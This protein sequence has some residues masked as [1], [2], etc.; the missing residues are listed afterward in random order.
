MHVASQ[1]WFFCSGINYHT[2]ALINI[3]FK[4]TFFSFKTLFVFIAQYINSNI[5]VPGRVYFVCTYTI[6]NYCNYN[7]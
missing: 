1:T 3:I 6:H 5:I 7:L 2:K 4:D